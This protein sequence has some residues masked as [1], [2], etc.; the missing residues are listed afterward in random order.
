[1]EC[2]VLS[3]ALVKLPLET[4]SE[5][6]TIPSRSCVSDAIAYARRVIKC[7]MEIMIFQMKY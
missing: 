3:A 4:T 1:M 6:I 2:P 7:H 5:K